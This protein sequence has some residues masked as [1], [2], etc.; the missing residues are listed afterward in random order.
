MI[1]IDSYFVNKCVLLVRKAKCLN[2]NH[3]TE[4]KCFWKTVKLFLSNEV[5]SSER[6][7]LTEEY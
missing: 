5:Q 2:E 3:V 6:I 1:K 7:K 4:Y